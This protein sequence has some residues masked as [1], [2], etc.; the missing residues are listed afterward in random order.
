MTLKTAVFTLHDA[1][2]ITVVDTA[3]APNAKSALAEFKAYK[4]AKCVVTGEGAGTFLVPFHAVIKVEV[5][6]QEVEDPSVSDNF[7]PTDET[8]EP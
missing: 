2:T 7:C 8:P 1:S 6:E 5:S 4:T 3:D